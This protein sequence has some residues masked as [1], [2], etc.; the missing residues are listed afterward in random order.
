[1]RDILAERGARRISRV[2]DF[3]VNSGTGGRAGGREVVYRDPGEDL[4]V[5]PWIVVGPVM[6]FL[7][8]PGE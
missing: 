1:M 4:V 7:V 3:V 2:S 8:D 6:E 5:G